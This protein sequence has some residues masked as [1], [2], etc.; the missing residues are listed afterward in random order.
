M[1]PVGHA[2][3]ACAIVWAATRHAQAAE[4]HTP[5]HIDY[6][7]VVLGALLPDLIDKPLVWWIVPSDQAGGHHIGH[8]L[9]FS[10]ALIA[11]GLLLSH[12]AGDNRLLLLGIG[13]LSHVLID[14]TTHIPRSL[15]WPFVTLHIEWSK[16]LVGSTNIAGEFFGSIVVL[17][18]G[19]RLWRAGK[20]EP[21][22]RYGRL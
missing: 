21:A 7:F 20:L 5:A 12:R 3:S 14:S 10:A 13:S 22:L 1:Y 8:A 11:A 9:L 4:A 17:A 18:L 6:R 15:L 2:V 19:W 16:L